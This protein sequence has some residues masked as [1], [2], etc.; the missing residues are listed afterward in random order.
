MIVRSD[1]FFLLCLLQMD[2]TQ[3]QSTK[4]PL[5]ETAKPKIFKRFLY[6]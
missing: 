3:L 5:I 6:F 2:S 4:I 1:F